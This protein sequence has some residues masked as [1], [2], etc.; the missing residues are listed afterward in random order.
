LVKMLHEGNKRWEYG[1]KARA[2][3]VRDFAPQRELEA[4]LRVYEECLSLT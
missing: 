2:R 1:Q 4:Y 3:V